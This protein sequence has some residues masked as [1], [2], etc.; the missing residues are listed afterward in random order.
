MVEALPKVEAM[1]P[2]EFVEE[3][4]EI[5]ETRKRAFSARYGLGRNYTWSGS[6][7]ANV[8]FSQD[9][10]DSHNLDENLGKKARAFRAKWRECL[11]TRSR[12]VASEGQRIMGA[13]MCEELLW[14]AIENYDAPNDWISR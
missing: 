10:Q 6:Q 4:H 12:T 11:D 2:V 13:G 8:R 3:L 1:L 9:A 5:I 14:G 7:A